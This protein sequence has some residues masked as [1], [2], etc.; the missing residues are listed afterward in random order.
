MYNIFNK[1]KSGFI[2]FIKLLIVGAAF[3]FITIKIADNKT[4]TNAQFLNRL[5]EN[6]LNSYSV[7]LILILFT[8][9]N[10]LLE[11]TKWKILVSTIK[12]ITLFEASKQSLS[13]LT[14]SLLTP[15]RI[16]EY[17][18]KAIYYPKFE[19]RSVLIL[20]L[21]GNLSQ[22]IATIFFGIIGLFLFEENLSIP[23]I[24]NSL[25]WIVFASISL[26]II[27]LILK[28]YWV[29][30]SLKI[31]TDFKSITNKI[32]AKNLT[33]SF[34]RYLVFSHQFYFLLMIFGTEIN[35][36]TA[37]PIIFA[38]YFISSITPSFVIFDWLIKGSVAVSLFNLY[39]INEIIILSIT[40][41]M[42]LLNF[43][44]PSVIGSYF[45]LTFKSENFILNENKISL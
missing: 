30:Y 15:N 5:Q 29:K 14:A 8:L 43:A 20:N 17:G 21:I 32:H 24:N 18:A 40:S 41:L 37:M 34:I 3:Y 1:Y 4:L 16:G 19:R 42:W 6:I 44:I 12:S 45:V 22:M 33:L 27:V 31:L 28:K 11:I 35:Y 9:V 26:F 38:M 39:G 10:W 23:I 2:F 25:K 13:S 36:S 7:L